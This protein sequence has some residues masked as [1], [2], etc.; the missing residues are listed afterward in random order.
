PVPEQNVRIVGEDVVGFECFS[1]PGHAYHHVSYLADDG[2]LYTGDA[3]GV[4]IH[5]GHHAL[6][7][8]PPPD[9]DVQAWQATL[10]EIERRQPER[11][12]LIHFGVAE[13]VDR[14]LADL[15]ERL[16]LWSDWVA[17]D[18]DEREFVDRA[19]R[20]LELDEG[21]GAGD[22]WEKAASFAQS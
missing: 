20:E 18:T 13:D 5:P 1:T 16:Q 2:T 19:R 22:L 12:A 4:R 21:D 3:A 9:I 15:R 10:D 14:H 7:G 8:S 17:E 11:L 6:P